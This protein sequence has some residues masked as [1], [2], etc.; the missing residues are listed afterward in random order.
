MTSP[1]AVS[2]PSPATIGLSL[3]A[4]GRERA[5]VFD[6]HMGA[7]V[8][9]RHKDVS[10]ALRDHGTFSTRF[11]AA[12]PA[13]ETM[14]ITHDGA[15]HTRQRR[16][17]NRFFS[18]G[19][20]ARY[21]AR[22]APIAERTFGDLVGRERSDLIEDALA[23][24]P[25]EVFL[26]LL[27][28]PN[29]LGDQGLAWVRAI[30]AWL[31]S[32]MDEQLAAAGQA[33]FDELCGYA[34]TLI[35]AEVAD[36]GDNLLGEII[37]AHL[38]EG[39]FT[40]EA[41]TVAVVSLLLGGLETTIQMLSATMSSLLLNPS[42]LDRVR[43][44]RSL[45]DAALDESFRWANPSAGLYRLVTADT[46]VAGV[47]VGAGSMVYLCIASAHYDRDA[48]PDPEVFHL[49]RHASHLGFGL[50]PHYCVGAPLARIEVRAALDA[51][52]DRF[53]RLRLDPDQPL[54]FRYGARGFVQHGA[55]TLPV[56]LS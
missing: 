43:A 42:A 55:D 23:R 7:L 34:G 50:G 13:V 19:A 27:G 16:I 46:V 3:A 20:S 2:S 21:A 56:L 28:I 24:Y 30:V 9:L 32:P 54:A 39:G 10:A 14:M 26:D 38:T 31:G 47:P 33:A 18:P 35:E 8:V 40:V 1:F 44:D 11:Y 49:D 29:E 51:L 12:S 17:H 52:L 53:P 4:V 22:I 37:R 6:E 45:R 41:C 25:M 15:E 36:P 5:T 48:Y